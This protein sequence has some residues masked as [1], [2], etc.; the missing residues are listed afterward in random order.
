MKRDE[1]RSN[2]VSSNGILSGRLDSV[3]T[4]SSSSVTCLKQCFSVPRFVQIPTYMDKL[5]KRSDP[6][7]VN[8]VRMSWERQKNLIAMLLRDPGP[9]RT[10]DATAYP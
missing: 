2:V 4:R 3:L 8:Q 1:G 6:S 5:E 9:T 7:A 10:S